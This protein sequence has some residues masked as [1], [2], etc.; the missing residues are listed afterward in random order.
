MVPANQIKVAA[1]QTPV[2]V[3]Q[4]LVIDNQAPGESG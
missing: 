3:D 2:S 4:A 1:H